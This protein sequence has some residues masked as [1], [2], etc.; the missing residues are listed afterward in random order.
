MPSRKDILSSDPNTKTIEFGPLSNAEVNGFNKFLVIN[1][2]G[3]TFFDEIFPVG[4]THEQVRIL[5]LLTTEAT[6]AYVL[7]LPERFP[8]LQE[9]HWI[10]AYNTDIAKIE[11]DEQKAKLWEKVVIF[12]EEQSQGISKKIL[13]HNGFPN[14]AEL[15]VDY[16]SPSENNGKQLI[17]QLDKAPKLEKLKVGNME[18]LL[19]DLAL[20]N[21]KARNL[22]TLHLSNIWHRKEKDNVSSIVA[23]NLKHLKLE[24]MKRKDETL[25]YKL[26]LE[27]HWMNFIIDYF[28]KM[29]KLTI[30]HD[31]HQNGEVTKIRDLK[32]HAKVNY[33]TLINH[34]LDKENVK[35]VTINP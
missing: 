35:Y 30:Y 8:D 6:A 34:C 18:M 1:K 29:E 20:L 21:G 17:E 13:E 33:I 9:F 23:E 3:L 2:K 24:D 27:P 19:S 10:D 25:G 26:K 12:K 7:T 31:P 28:T 14:L 4:S 5:Y 32:E 22:E 11:V 16:Y 15:S